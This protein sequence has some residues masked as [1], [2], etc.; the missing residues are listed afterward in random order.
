MMKKTFKSA[1]IVET[2]ERKQY[3]IGCKPGDVAPSILLCGDP[4]RAHRVAT[5]FKNAKEPILSREFVT[6]T[7]QYKDMPMTVMAT[8]MGPGNTEIAFIEL[9]QIV[10]DPTLIRIGSSGAL[11]DGI[12]LADLVISTAAVRMETT[13]SHF[14]VDGYPASAHHEVILAL[15]EAARKNGFPYH[16]GL[17]ATAPG[18]YGAQSRKVPGFTPR[19]E[20]LPEKLREM[21]VANFEMEASVLFTLATLRGFRAGAVCAIYAT[22]RANEFIDIDTKDLAEKRCIE[23]GLAAFEV[24]A[25]MDEASGDSGSWSPSMGLKD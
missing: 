6:I 20:E 9:S 17:T 1:E 14:V 2:E 15:V 25:M 18:F 16:L 19:D 10:E 8:G 7:G 3:H 21:N 13:S 11:K 24:L 12:E 5:Y 22:R 4:A 23:T